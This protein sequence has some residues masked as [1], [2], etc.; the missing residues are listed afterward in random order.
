[1]RQ[2]P[3]APWMEILVFTSP[4]RGA[5]QWNIFIFGNRTINRAFLCH[6]LF[7]LPKKYGLWT[8]L[9]LPKAAMRQW[10]NW[11]LRRGGKLEIWIEFYNIKI[12]SIDNIAAYSKWCSFRDGHQKLEVYKWAGTFWLRIS[13]TSKKVHTKPTLHHGLLSATVSTLCRICQ[14]TMIMPVMTTDTLRISRWLSTILWHFK[15]NIDFS[16]DHA[17]VKSCA[18]KNTHVMLT[19]KKVSMAWAKLGFRCG[20]G[21]GSCEW[22]FFYLMYFSTAR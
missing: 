19:R 16:N 10:V 12:L 18:L 9:P 11:S 5:H 17:V 15:R 22:A 3:S 4:L 6:Q 1:M 20:C 14:C 7:R 13:I 21:P 2:Q 8:V